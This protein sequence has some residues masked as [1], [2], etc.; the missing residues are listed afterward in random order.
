MTVTAKELAARLGVSVDVVEKRID[1]GW[2]PTAERGPGRG[3][4]YAINN[5]DALRSAPLPEHAIGAC[6]SRTRLA[7]LRIARALPLLLRGEVSDD[8]LR[9]LRQW[10]TLERLFAFC[11]AFAWRLAFLYLASDH[12]VGCGDC[13][14]DT[15]PED[16]HRRVALWEPDELVAATTDHHPSWHDPPTWR[17]SE[18]AHARNTHA[19]LV[20]L[21]V[22]FEDDP[23]QFADAPQRSALHLCEQLSRLRIY[24]LGN[25]SLWG[26]RRDAYPKVR[27]GQSV[28]PWD[29]VEYVRRFEGRKIPRRER[30]AEKWRINVNANDAL[31]GLFRENVE[32][33]RFRDEHERTAREHVRNPKVE[34]FDLDTLD[35]LDGIRRASRKRV[36]WWWRPAEATVTKRPSARA[37]LRGLE[38]AAETE[39]N[40][41]VVFGA[42]FAAIALRGA[43]KR[44]HVATATA[45]VAEHG[46]A[47]AYGGDDARLPQPPMTDEDRAKVRAL[48]LSWRLPKFDERPVERCDHFPP[49]YAPP[50]FTK[51]DLKVHLILKARR[52]TAA[53]GSLPGALTK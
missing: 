19:Y 9:G 25:V 46:R 52:L 4:P 21:W 12:C 1:E 18:L 28:A 3:R 42:S 24:R 35:T 39:D 27:V 38:E 17:E 32:E 22:Q 53:R 26:H 13:A 43:L 2:F 50:K 16:R 40:P 20:R 44:G 47:T 14:E 36:P 8:A 15:R 41:D 49:C 29:H 34:R 10:R 11:E 31:R 45:L 23:S 6:V 51:A 37:V 5:N 48:R 33:R 30:S 7:F